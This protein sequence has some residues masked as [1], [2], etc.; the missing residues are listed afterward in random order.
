MSACMR[1]K[2]RYIY[3][4][5]ENYVKTTL[6]KV[7]GE[8]P[9]PQ[10]QDEIRSIEDLLPLGALAIFREE[11]LR[12]GSLE[13]SN[14]QSKKMVVPQSTVDYI[15]SWFGSISDSDRTDHPDFADKEDLALM[16]TIETKLQ[17]MTE[18][19][20]V[21]A[22]QVFPL[23]IA[24]RTSS[25]LSLTYNRIP[26]A[27]L[28]MALSFGME[29][30]YGNMSMKLGMDNFSIEDIC[31]AKP[32][33]KY[34]V[35][36]AAMEDISSTRSGSH[37]LGKK[38][39][40]SR[41]Q[42][43]LFFDIE[44]TKSVMLIRA[45]PLI[46]TWNK[47]CLQHLLGFV[48]LGTADD[49]YVS[50]NPVLKETYSAES[51]MPETDLLIKIDIDA[52][53][54]ILPEDMGNS[55]RCT[56]L[57]TGTLT[58]D[59]L[60]NAC[61]MKWDIKLKN[62]NIAMPVAKNALNIT[63][64]KGD[65]YLIKPFD[66]SAILSKN[67]KESSELSV[68]SRVDPELRAEFTPEK[69][70]RLGQAV[71]ALL[72]GLNSDKAEVR[73]KRARSSMIASNLNSANY[74]PPTRPTPSANPT[75]N[76]DKEAVGLGVT[77][78]LNKLALRLSFSSNNSHFIEIAFTK[79]EY[80]LYKR[81]FDDTMTCTLNSLTIFDSQRPIDF[82]Y[83]IL[84]QSD[85]VTSDLSNLFT[86]TLRSFSSKNSSFYGGNAMDMSITISVINLYL[87]DKATLGYKSL[88]DELI[89]AYNVL[90]ISTSP[91]AAKKNSSEEK[92]NNRNVKK[93]EEGTPP[94]VIS[95]LG[96]SLFDFSLERVSLH[97][98]NSDNSNR[99]IG[100]NPSEI[101][102][103]LNVNDLHLSYQM[104]D[105]SKGFAKLHSVDIIDLRSLSSSPAF[106][107]LLSSSGCENQHSFEV[108]ERNK[109]QL[110]HQ[111]MLEVDFKQ[112]AVNVMSIE[113][114]IMSPKLVINLDVILDLVAIVMV[115]VDAWLNVLSSIQSNDKEPIE[116]VVDVIEPFTDVKEIFSSDEEDENDSG[117]PNDIAVQSESVVQD[118][119]TI[120]LHILDPQLLLIENPES[121]S[122]RAIVGKSNIGLVYRKVFTCDIQESEEKVSLTAEESQLIVVRNLS[123]PHQIHRIID[124]TNLHVDFTRRSEKD[125]LL[126]LK[127]VFCCLSDVFI[128]VS[129]NDLVLAGAIV[130]R[131]TSNKEDPNIDGDG[132][133]I[134]KQHIFLI[135]DPIE[136]V[137]DDS[138]AWKPPAFDSCIY[139]VLST[140]TKVTVVLINDCNSQNNPLLRLEIDTGVLRGGGPLLGFCVEGSIFVNMDYYNIFLNVWEPVIERWMPSMSLTKDSKGTNLLLKNIGMIQLN[141][142]GTL[143]KCITNAISLVSRSQLNVITTRSIVAPLKFSNQLGIAVEL[144][145][146][147]KDISI[148]RLDD[149][150]LHELL[151]P[152]D[153]NDDSAL[154]WSRPRILYMCFR[155]DYEGLFTPLRQLSTAT[156]TK[157]KIYHLQP[158]RQGLQSSPYSTKGKSFAEVAPSSPHIV[159][160]VICKPDE[161]REIFIRTT[162]VIVNDLGVDIEFSMGSIVSSTTFIIKK[163]AR[164][165]IPLKSIHEQTFRIRPV[166]TKCTW[167]E[168][169]PLF[170]DPNRKDTKSPEFCQVSFF[171]EYQVSSKVGI[172]SQE[173]DGLFVVTCYALMEVINRLPCDLKLAYKNIS[174]KLDQV[175]LSS[176]ETKSLF[177]FESGSELEIV[178][179][180][181]GFSKTEKIKLPAVNEDVDLICKLVHERSGKCLFYSLRVSVNSSR[182]V[183]LLIYSK[184]LLCDRTDLSVSVAT[185]LGDRKEGG[186]WEAVSYNTTVSWNELG[187]LPSSSSSN[188]RWIYGMAGQALLQPLNGKFL[189]MVNRGSAQTNQ[190]DMESLSTAKSKIDVY[191][192]STNRTYSIAAHLMPYPTAPDLSRVLYVTPAFHVI[193][194]MRDQTLFIQQ[195]NGDGGEFP[196]EPLSARAWH[197]MGKKT[198]S[199]DIIF[200]TT[201]SDWSIGK[202]DINDIGTSVILL[203][204]KQSKVNPNENEEILD[205]ASDPVVLNI[206]V[207]FSASGDPSYITI[208]VWESKIW[209]DPISTKFYRL[210]T[211]SF[212]IRNATNETII[213]RQNSLDVVKLMKKLARWTNLSTEDDAKRFELIV[214]PGE[215][216]AYGWADQDLTSKM[217][218]AFGCQIIT[219]SHGKEEY[220]FDTA[221][222]VVTIP[223]EK[224][225]HSVRVNSRISVQVKTNA[226]GKFLQIGG[227]ASPTGKHGSR[228]SVA[229]RRMSALSQD[230]VDQL[231][232]NDFNL[233]LE[234]DCVAVSMIADRPNR[235][236]FLTL[237]LHGI[238]SALTLISASEFE[239]ATTMLSFTVQ[240]AQIDNYSQS[241]IYPVLLTT[242]VGSSANVGENQSAPQSPE[243]SLPDSNNQIGLGEGDDE[244]MN[245]NT[246]IYF[247]LVQQSPKEQQMSIIKYLGFRMLETRISIDSASI[248][249]YMSD[250]HRDLLEGLAGVD[251]EGFSTISLTESF[252]SSVM[253]E[254]SMTSTAEI[255]KD[256]YRECEKA[257]TDKIVIESLEIH[258]IKVVINFSPSHYPRS[259]KEIPA[260]VRWMTKIET[261]S[262]VEDFAIKIKSFKAQDAMESVST[263]TDRILQKIINDFTH[264]LISLTKNLI[265]SMNALGKPAGLYKKIGSGVEDFFYEVLFGNCLFATR[266]SRSLSLSLSQ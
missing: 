228:P 54:I 53:K 75:V 208:T 203:P 168:G 217:D 219:N 47:H 153:L 66:I 205:L 173:V 45:L 193:N 139:E 250:L 137:V 189:I 214:P 129:L 150:S 140:V 162:K 28:Q 91:N 117:N 3:I 248:L 179:M 89:N 233:R 120:R 216:R 238:Q 7:R 141:V 175:S 146:A 204:K 90:V 258:P 199:T 31:S 135:D 253:K 41:S 101:A 71:A 261:V 149:G 39:S 247:M 178:P 11:A 229:S 160:E 32:Y 236:E 147:A 185:G 108:S 148:M 58:L 92:I 167:T 257:Q 62:I 126:E 23:R 265:L 174:K 105:L 43:E 93:L 123:A 34:L 21:V 103:S 187:I 176:G 156:A 195:S 186:M 152:S 182:V 237:Y 192:A 36:M 197:A 95:P 25:T 188:D 242:T 161:S 169:I 206:D 57:D 65:L 17:R 46:I 210:G 234:L 77:F 131:M 104:H 172:M 166:N 128:R 5:K 40:P 218:I 16:G 59:G 198:D 266:S 48:I 6:A 136:E 22:N 109:P 243:K 163:G 222:N 10:Y 42:F 51:A 19:C 14:H 221:K 232:I 252:N 15:S 157:P 202:V 111:E 196:L 184:V 98:L 181:G 76:I 67:D 151:C 30:R 20:S 55:E 122:S 106:R 154:D 212:S 107:A 190:I 119:I 142:T 24:V 102:F 200:R 29:M 220:S 230:M 180:I 164:R 68:F 251:S 12:L 115:N 97:I 256:I 254:L 262:P 165:C 225:G 158:S 145:D 241:V 191:D 138:R 255:S 4:T 84:A 155:D 78:L 133:L 49:S 26:F 245:T 100:Q 99:N 127:V 130:G 81:L 86:L 124:P 74:V 125:V 56:I 132:N 177:N 94:H 72:S 114:K 113:V 33:N 259:K 194:A 244:T 224:V 207:R 118:D 170:L 240:G 27:K 226:H 13:I 85:V 215:W 209:R 159:W 83:L 144:F 264:N 249:L 116:S 52:P 79:I 246:F 38:D 44:P 70:V 211:I 60:L 61:G 35:C 88:V 96:G 260:M 50:N 80:K 239:N 87:D 213:V 183:T 171:D 263:L 9:A 2:D 227:I 18:D 73:T 82:P 201:H 134:E 143:L 63:S 1:K 69:I 64:D 112:Y 231:R 235:R 223:T 37:E 121:P 110:H 8:K